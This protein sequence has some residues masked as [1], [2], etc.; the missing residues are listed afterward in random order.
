MPL[1]RILARRY[2]T[3]LNCVVAQSA[4]HGAVDLQMARDLI[5]GEA[6][7]SEH[8]NRRFGP[9]AKM[10]RRGG[11]GMAGLVGHGKCGCGLMHGD[12][13]AVG[14][15]QDFLCNTAQHDFAQPPQTAPP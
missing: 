8:G 9:R 1:C 2:A 7:I 5:L 13:R 15:M 10:V 6:Q 14:G 4:H 12:D 11:G 3:L